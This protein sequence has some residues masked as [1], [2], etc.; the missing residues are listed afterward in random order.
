[1][2]VRVCCRSAV[3]VVTSNDNGERTLRELRPNSSNGSDLLKLMDQTR[4][5]RRSWIDREHPTITAIMKRYPR[6]LDMNSAVSLYAMSSSKHS[7]LVYKQIPLLPVLQ[8]SM[9]SPWP[10]GQIVLALITRLIVAS[11][12][13]IN[14]G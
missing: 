13:K 9:P 1:M 3:T 10:Q 12:F 2:I 4:A 7:K 8:F 5:T 6:F 14:A 11:C